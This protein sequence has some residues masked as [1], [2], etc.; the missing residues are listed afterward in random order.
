M[1][2]DSQPLLVDI[3]DLIYVFLK[4]I[5][6]IVLFGLLFSGLIFGYKLYKTLNE[7]KANDYSNVVSLFNITSKLPEETDIEYSKRVLNVNR[8]ND[9]VNSVNVIKRQIDNHRKYV[10][11][12]VFMTINAENEA[13]T[14]VN[15]VVSV[16]QS[17][18]TNIDMAL[19]SSYKQ[20][21]QSGEYL[22]GLSDDLG[23][24]QGYITELI[25]VDYN[26]SSISIN[27]ISDNGSSGVMS[28]KVIG[29]TTEFTEKVMSSI[30]ENI[31]VKQNELVKSV[32]PHNVVV[33]SLQSSYIVDSSTRDRQVS[34]INRFETL[35]QQI[36]NFDKI[37]DTVSS[38][39][40]VSKESIY[41]FYSSDDNNYNNELSVSYKSAVLY[42]AIGFVLGAIF[43]MAF[44]TLNYIF[45]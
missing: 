2:Q 10:A 1:F 12:S 24:D 38:N 16:D 6:Y 11:E 18:S 4:K 22:S 7:S 40:G 9:L 39:L 19:L 31:N 37:L 27:N 23:I 13:I 35:E 36:I 32:T 43:V 44:Y 42:A 14:S 26:A 25:S 41:S 3:K 17:I 34:A 21:I 45:V 28:I 33:A 20:Y 15:L 30:L 5:I 29:P 8:A